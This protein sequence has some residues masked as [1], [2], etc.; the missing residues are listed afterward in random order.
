MENEKTED[1]YWI[2]H[3][4]IRVGTKFQFTLIS[5]T[6]WT[7]FAQKGYFQSKAENVNITNEFCIFELG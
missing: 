2:V 6:F 4:R 1:R 3:I 5:L 7:I